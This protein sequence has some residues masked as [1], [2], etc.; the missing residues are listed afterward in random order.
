MSVHEIGAFALG[1]ALGCLTQ[2]LIRRDPNPGIADLAAIVAVI[3]GAAVFKAVLGESE[4]SWYLIG[5]GVGFFL[6]WVALLLGHGRPRTNGSS[7][8]ESDRGSV[9]LFPFLC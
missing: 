3:S 6:C 4:T 2:N 7:G 9:T 5:V 1:A 8:I